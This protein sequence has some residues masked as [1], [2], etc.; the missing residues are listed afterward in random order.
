MK[1]MK[2][3]YN[4]LFIFLTTVIIWSAGCN[5]MYRIEGNGQVVTET[6]QLVSFN[7]VENDGTFN[8][9]IRHDSVFSAVVEAESNLIPHIRT[10]VNGNTLEIDTHENLNTNYPINLY[11]TT[12]IITGA[13]LNGSGSVTLDSLDTENMEVDL[14]GSGIMSGVLTSNSLT[15]R[16]SG[17]GKINLNAHT[18]SCIA[19]I[20]GSGDIELV[21]ETLSG[22]F[23][24]SGSGNIQSTNFIQNECIAKI[25]GSGNMY[26]NVTE[27]LDVTITGS[28]SVYYVGNPQVNVKITGSGSIIKQN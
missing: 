24:I 5:K 13:Y 21:G 3:K 2:T 20:S 6:R 27:Y 26:L 22:D 9:Y 4:I 28:G 25:S 14:S 8:V 7:K 11:I 19:R 23:S 1:K 12:P 15:T 18:N 10:R 17:S 16:I